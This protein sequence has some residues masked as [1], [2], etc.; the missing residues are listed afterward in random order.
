MTDLTPIPAE[1]RAAYYDALLAGRA[2]AERLGYG[3]IDD[4]IFAAFHRALY[5]PMVDAARADERAKV[6]EDIA[7]AIE[8]VK[9]SAARFWDTADASAAY[10]LNHAAAIARQHAQETS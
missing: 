2:E 4:R 9:P 7:R 8:A 10:A 1:Q 3:P 5:R 6:A